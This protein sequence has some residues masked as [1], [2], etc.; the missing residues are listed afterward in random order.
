VHTAI[1][2]EPNPLWQFDGSV[3]LLSPTTSKG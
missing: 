3:D 1:G 2:D